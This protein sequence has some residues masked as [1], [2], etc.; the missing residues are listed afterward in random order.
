M[1]SKKRI[2]LL[3]TTIMM[4]S[5]CL[6]CGNNTMNKIYNDN[7]KIA[8]VSDTF[9]LDE[10]TE[11]IKSGIYKG[12]LKL[13]GCG[14]IW[15]YQSST[16]F[17]LKIPY[18]LSVNSGKAKIVLISPDNTVVNLVENTDEAT[19]KGVTSLTAPIKKGNN[20]IK[21]VGYEKSDIDIELHIDKG[22]FEEIRLN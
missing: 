3:T 6:G 14:T 1:T 22:T 2:V 5:L 17:D 8:N 16:D 18:T 21:V 9:G 13:S 12:K 11:T 19:I 7:S 10:S 15:T 20:R 4:I